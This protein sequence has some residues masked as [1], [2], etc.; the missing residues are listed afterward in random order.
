MVRKG[1]RTPTG[2][3]QLAPEAS[4]S[5]VPPLPQVDFFAVRNLTTLDN[6]ERGCWTLRPPSR[7]QQAIQYMRTHPRRQ[8]TTEKIGAPLDLGI[9]TV[10]HRTPELFGKFSRHRRM[11]QDRLDASGRRKVNGQPAR[12]EG[13]RHLEFLYVGVNAVFANH[14]L[15]LVVRSD[16]SEC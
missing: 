10:H 9:G 2:L 12:V 7:C 11:H 13:E 1:I 16:L 15:H 6:N 3:L 8:Q 5:A 14:G 4:A